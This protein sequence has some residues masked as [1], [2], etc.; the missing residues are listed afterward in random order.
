VIFKNEEP[1]RPQQPGVFAAATAMSA[2]FGS[3]WGT[4]AGLG[5]ARPSAAEVTL[6][7]LL[8]ASLLAL[9]AFRGLYLK[10]WVA[11]WTVLVFSR[12]AEHTLAARIPAPFD[13]VVVHAS[14]VL[15]VGLLAGAVL[16]YTRSKDLI[17]P[18]AVITPILIGFAGA[19][20]LLWPE[21]LPARVGVEV[22]YRIVLL[23]AS[24]ALL[25]ARRGGWQPSAWL[26]AL[27]R[28]CVDLSL[29]SVNDRVS[30]TAWLSA[31]I[32]LGLSM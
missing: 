29:P 2:S 25:S 28:L 20:V 31:E 13:L 7:V 9:R 10:I 1:V 4:M 24:I 21:S 27:S 14:F 15:A 19:R 23:T 8:G 26:L 6:L 11:G 22:A 12:L 17:V 30:S 18:L 32:A 5:V 16:V 3:I